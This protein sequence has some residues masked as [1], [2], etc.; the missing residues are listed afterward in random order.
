MR[1]FF[2]TNIWLSAIVFPGLCAELLVACDEAGHEWLSSE[3]IRQET[4]AVLRRKF[5][6]HAGA[7]ARFDLLWARATIVMD[8]TE[9]AE[10]ADARLVAAA[11]AAQADLFITGDARVQAWQA[12]GA[13]R[14][15][16]PRGAWALLTAG[17]SRPG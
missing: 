3:L 7:A 1:V 16:G 17:A 9:P 13:M 14:I 12:R 8:V 10:D 15:V 5:V 2:D 11:Q 4:H 6:G